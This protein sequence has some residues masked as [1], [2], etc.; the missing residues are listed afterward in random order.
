MSVLHSTTEQGADESLTIISIRRI[1]AAIV[2]ER[3]S[4][5]I[6]VTDFK[7][8][9]ESFTAIEVDRFRV[10]EDDVK[11]SEN[12]DA[13]FFEL[14]RFSVYDIGRMVH[15]GFL[16]LQALPN[17]RLKKVESRGSRIP[18]MLTACECHSDL[19]PTTYAATRPQ[20]LFSHRL[21]GHL[22][23]SMSASKLCGVCEGIAVLGADPI[24]LM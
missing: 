7:E 9:K 5:L 11:N 20:N 16:V 3:I 13:S 4:L 18:E 15:E 2:L 23:A 12:E 22:E 21:Y 8:V 19:L 6:V 17:T 10:H 1:F 14:D 24:G